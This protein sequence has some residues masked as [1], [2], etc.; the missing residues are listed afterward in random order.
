MPVPE[1]E[2]PVNGPYAF[3]WRGTQNKIS[4]FN[5]TT[6]TPTVSSGNVVSSTGQKF[7]VDRSQKAYGTG[8]ITWNTLARIANQ[9]HL[10]G[11]KKH[12]R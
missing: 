8:E 10:P 9:H 3:T 6:G 7:E 12:Q 4:G 2:D 5:L 1:V 11:I